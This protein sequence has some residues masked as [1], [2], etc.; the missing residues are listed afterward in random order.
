YG[1]DVKIGD[2]V[3]TV[4]RICGQI[5]RL[6]LI[7]FRMCRRVWLRCSPRSQFPRENVRVCDVPW[8]GAGVA[9]RRR[10]EQP[11]SSVLS[12][13]EWRTA[14][15]SNRP[16]MSSTVLTAAS[17]GPGDREPLTFT[18]EVCLIPFVC[19]DVFRSRANQYRTCLTSNVQC[20]KRL[21]ALNE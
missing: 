20:S 14:H 7:P 12:G 4:P 5:C 19:L 21:G 13:C 3:E 17:R 11:G 15:P 6:V 9:K 1:R 10:E 2:G 16:N 8:V 18:S